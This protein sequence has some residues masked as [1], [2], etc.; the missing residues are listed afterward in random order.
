[1]G[2][3]WCGRVPCAC[4]HWDRLPEQ[5]PRPAGMAVVRLLVT[6]LRPPDWS[7]G[8]LATQGNDHAGNTATLAPPSPGRAGQPERPRRTSSSSVT[9]SAGAGT[10]CSKNKNIISCLFC[11]FQMFT[12]SSQSSQ[13][14]KNIIFPEQKTTSREHRS[15]SPGPPAVSVGSEP[16]TSAPRPCL[17]LGGPFRSRPFSGWCQVV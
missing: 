13:S 1:M 14:H 9:R 8:P 10:F 2:A 3:P 17:L 12:S 7:R 11:S 5:S 6:W 16:R 15:R 4:P